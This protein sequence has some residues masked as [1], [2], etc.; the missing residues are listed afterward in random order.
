MNHC[1]DLTNIPWNC[2]GIFWKNKIK[3]KNVRSNFQNC[4]QKRLLVFAR[5]NCCA[6]EF[7]LCKV[8]GVCESKAI[9]YEQREISNLY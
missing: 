3:R 8:H 6:D 7:Y 1:A 5:H 2:K 9:A 4:P